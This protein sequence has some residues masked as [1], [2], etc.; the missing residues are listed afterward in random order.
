M[1]VDKNGNEV[2]QG[3]RYV[4]LTGKIDSST[5]LQK[6]RSI[7]RKP[8]KS[9]PLSSFLVPALRILAVNEEV[10]I[11]CINMKGKEVMLPKAALIEKIQAK[12]A[13]LLANVAG[14][15]DG[16]E[17]KD[18]AAENS[19]ELNAER[20]IDECLEQ[21]VFLDWEGYERELGDL[22]PTGDCHFE[23]YELLL[24]L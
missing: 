6:L 8:L 18:F 21:C 4:E 5:G 19:I 1:W 12:R 16:D 10:D 7:Y 3:G 14:D 2:F 17:T 20:G 11:T 15:Y 9:K 22:A 24:R 13:E 23:A